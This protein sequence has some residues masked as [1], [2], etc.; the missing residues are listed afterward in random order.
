MFGDR[1]SKKCA[2]PPHPRYARLSVGCGREGSKFQGSGYRAGLRWSFAN[3][4]TTRVPVGI[5]LPSIY[6]SGP[7]FRRIATWGWAIRSVS[8]MSMSR[9]G[10]SF[11]HAERGI[12]DSVVVVEWRG[13]LHS[14]MLSG[15][16]EAISFL[17]STRASL[18]HFGWQPRYV[19]IQEA[20]IRSI[21]LRSN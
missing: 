14:E 4:Y 9:M 5:T 19:S 13:V 3:G 12:E 16:C 10:V 2:P 1:R 15:K 18:R 8:W 21:S 11:S 6:I 20:G 7:I 17:I